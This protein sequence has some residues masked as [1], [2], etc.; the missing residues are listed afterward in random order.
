M[1]SPSETTQLTAHVKTENK[2]YHQKLLPFDL[3]AFRENTCDIHDTS[4][5]SQ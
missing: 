4:F 3:K 5:T 2:M 1:A